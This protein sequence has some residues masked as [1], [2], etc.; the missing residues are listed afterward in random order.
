MNTTDEWRDDRTYSID[1]R[2]VPAEPE[3]P[4]VARARAIIPV[5]QKVK[6]VPLGGDLLPLALDAVDALDEM[7]TDHA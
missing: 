3:D 5:L 7:R 4:R 1:P 6:N 2:T